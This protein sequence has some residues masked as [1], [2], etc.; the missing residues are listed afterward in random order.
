MQFYD[1][2]KISIESGKGGNGIAS[3]R[4]ESGI[5]F[6]GPSGWDGGKGG[7]IIIKAN[8]DENTLL[9]YKYKKIFKAK[10]G[11]DGRTKDQ[12][13]ADAE[14]FVIIVPVETLVK[15]SESWKLLHHFTKDGE[16]RVALPGGDGGK[17]NIHFKD[18]INQYPNFFLLGEPGQKREVVLE[19][20]LLGDVG[21][22]GNPSVGKSSLINCAASTKA[23]VADY[24]FTTLVPNLGSVSV[25]DFRF[26]MVD[27]PGLIKGAADGKGL[28]NAFLRHVLKARVFAMVMDMARY[29][30]GIQE[31]INLFDEIIYYIEDKFLQ[32]IE[33]YHFAFEQEDNLIAF[34]VY[35]DWEIFLSKKVLFVLNK[36]D[37]IN[38]QEL[39][40]EFQK[41]LVE[42]LSIYFSENGFDELPDHLIKKNIFVTSA[43]TYQGVGELLRALAEV[44]R[45]TPVQS[46]PD[47]EPVHILLE[48]DGEEMISDVTEVEKP[49]LIKHDYLDEVSA[50]YT[51]VYFIQNPEICRLVFIIPRG[52]EEAELWFRKQMSQKGFIELFE[53][54]GI[55]KGDVLK[56]RSYYEG[57]DDKYIV[58]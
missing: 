2:V 21:L 22:I 11:E 35:V 42:N 43:W 15:D 40:E 27:I 58:Y 57:H 46:I 29:D 20:Q 28:G 37:L 6:G 38:D 34:N 33:E 13:G 10:N 39:L 36:Y 12:Y 55:R 44:L 32:D 30:E 14:D 45:K 47:I 48:E 24:P 1:E 53:Q 4:R 18:A 26:N 5:P 25:G 23:K 50:K 52:N 19:L 56:V 3:G 17:G 51:N 8:K 49:F 16:E 7:A 31:T 9:E 41:Q 54:F